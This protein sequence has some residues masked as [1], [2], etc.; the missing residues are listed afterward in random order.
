MGDTSEKAV[1]TWV[2]ELWKKLIMIEEMWGEGS[3][4]QGCHEATIQQEGD[5]YKLLT[6]RDGLVPSTHGSRRG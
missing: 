6:R 3:S 4:S 5:P 2:A 1:V